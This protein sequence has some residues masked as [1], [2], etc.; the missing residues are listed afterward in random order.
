MKLL[1]VLHN[2]LNP[3]YYI[4]LKYISSISDRV[5]VIG[6]TEEIEKKCGELNLKIVEFSDFDYMIYLYTGDNVSTGGGDFKKELERLGC[7][8]TPEKVDV[9]YMYATLD[10]SRYFKV[11]LIYRKDVVFYP[12]HTSIKH[13]T[14]SYDYTLF[15]MKTTLESTMLHLATRDLSKNLYCD[16]ILRYY[17]Y[18]LSGEF[19]LGTNDTSDTKI[20]EIDEDTCDEFEGEVLYQSKKYLEA[21]VKTKKISPLLRL[22]EY[23]LDQKDPITSYMFSR[24]SL[25]LEDSPIYFFNNRSDYLNNRYTLFAEVCLLLGRTDEGKLALSKTTADHPVREKYKEIQAKSI[26]KTKKQFINTKMEE[27][28]KLYPNL[29]NKQ[30]QSKIK[31]EWSKRK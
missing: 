3:D 14:F 17:K 11:P 4:T 12:N 7:N 28:S 22:A 30:L 20:Q 9:V 31:K 29:T 23:H 26:A 2:N 27:Y 16:F 15:V 8:E 18:L 10:K 1:P 25:E 6:I 21:F 24:M 19:P 13:S 5:C